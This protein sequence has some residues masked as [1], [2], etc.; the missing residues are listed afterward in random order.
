MKVAIT[1]GTGFIGRGLVLR[2]VAAGDT[3][4]T[5]VDSW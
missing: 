5:M 2:H 3:V 4:A 1:G